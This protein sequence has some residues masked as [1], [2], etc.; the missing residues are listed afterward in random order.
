MVPVGEPSAVRVAVSVVDWLG[1]DGLTELVRASAATL[2]TS[3]DVDGPEVAGDVGVGAGVD[4]GE[5]VGA[6]GGEAAGRLAAEPVTGTVHERAWCRQRT[7]SVPVGAPKVPSE[8]MVAVRLVDW[9]TSD[10]LTELVSV[11]EVAL[12]T[13]W[14][15]VAVPSWRVG[16][17]GV[18]GRD[19]VGAGCGE[20]VG[21]AGGADGA[22]TGDGDGLGAD[23]VPSL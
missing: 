21:D 16:V 22:G 7:G 4:R 12:P 15:S 1:S 11:T 10:G 8:V 14:V 18:D 5:S 2:R 13:T 17:A 3:C 19:G 23:G 20:A 9:P 6:C